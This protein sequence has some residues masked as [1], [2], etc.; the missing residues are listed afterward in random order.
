MYVAAILFIALNFEN[1]AV[2]KNNN[3]ITKDRLWRK[4]RM[5][6]KSSKCVGTDAN[7]NFDYQW[8]AEP[9]K[10]TSNPCSDVYA[11][12]HPFSQPETFALKNYL[13]SV[14]DKIQIYFALHSFGQFIFSPYS[15]SAKEKPNNNL[16]LMQISK[17]FTDAV[18]ALPYR[19]NYAA[20][21]AATL[22]CMLH[23]IVFATKLKH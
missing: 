16:D 5:P 14:K 6:N 22:L 3:L 8:V 20:G 10:P 12:S 9:N 17:A 4:T 1:L 19:T 15:F 18:I 7:R 21:S 2:S 11:G 13:L 23:L